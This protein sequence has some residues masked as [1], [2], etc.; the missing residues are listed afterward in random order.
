MSLMKHSG[1]RALVTASVAAFALAA[2][3]GSGSA[4]DKLPLIRATLSIKS[5]SQG[6]VCES[7]PVR[8]TPKEFIGQ[9]NKYANN[10]MMVAE[11]K[12]AGPTDENGAP[13][14]NGDGETL[15]LAPGNWEFSAPLASGSTACLR[16]IQADGD[17]SI[18]F[19]DGVEGCGDPGAAADSTMPSAAEAEV[20]GDSAEPTSS[21][22]PAEPPAG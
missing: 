5:V 2:C 11:V 3:G 15:P 4:N 10:R 18:V 7:V 8:M 19:I 12:M 21:E 22:T 13:M 16:N 14:C 9:A 20:P 17:L 6:G 1:L